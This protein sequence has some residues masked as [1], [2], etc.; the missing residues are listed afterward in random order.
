[1]LS[2]VI[3]NESDLNVGVLS[4]ICQ[5]SMV[6]NLSERHGSCNGYRTPIEHGTSWVLAPAGSNQAPH[7][8]CKLRL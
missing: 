7:T 2:K 4:T 1:M 8:W 6:A 5:L 3:W